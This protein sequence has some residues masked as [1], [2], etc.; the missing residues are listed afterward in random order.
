MSGNLDYEYQRIKMLEA[1]YTIFD[2][3]QYGR[4]VEESKFGNAFIFSEDRD[5]KE[6]LLWGAI[7]ENR[8]FILDNYLDKYNF[9]FAMVQYATTRDMINY[10]Y[11]HFKGS[12]QVNFHRYPYLVGK[13]RVLPLKKLKKQ[14]DGFEKDVENI[15]WIIDCMKASAENK[16]DDVYEYLYQ[17]YIEYGLNNYIHHREIASEAVNTGNYQLL[18][19]LINKMTKKDIKKMN[20][21]DVEKIKKYV[22]EGR[23]YVLE[24]RNVRLFE[25]KIPADVTRY[26][27]NRFLY[28]QI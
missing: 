20:K 2:W 10:L 8:F 11:H 12:I 27:V 26:I 22:L 21:D 5:I 7:R 9:R 6:A 25:T 18:E 19:K 14:I 17:K 28:P 1:E 23:K 24:R 13:C 4:K 16:N 15:E 3:Y